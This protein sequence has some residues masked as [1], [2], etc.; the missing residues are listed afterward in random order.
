MNQ[1]ISRIFVEIYKLILLFIWRPKDQEQIKT[2]LSKNKH[3]DI[4]NINTFFSY[5]N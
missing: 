5:S 3:L 1:I 4:L 2:L